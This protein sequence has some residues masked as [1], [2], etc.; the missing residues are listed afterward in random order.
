MK[1]LS[2]TWYFYLQPNGNLIEQWDNLD[3]PHTQYLGCSTNKG[4]VNLPYVQHFVCSNE[5]VIINAFMSCDIK[6][7]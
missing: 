4:Y 7:M 2:R 6:V 5:P 3:K 1:K